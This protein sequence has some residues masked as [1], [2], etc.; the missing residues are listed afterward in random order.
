MALGKDHRL[1]SQTVAGN[2]A[3]IIHMYMYLVFCWEGF[4]KPDDS[5]KS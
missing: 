2:W 5:G 4:V 1:L 3:F